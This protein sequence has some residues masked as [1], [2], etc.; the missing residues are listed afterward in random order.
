[1][2]DIMK[3]GALLLT[4]IQEPPAQTFTL[5]R[6]KAVIAISRMVLHMTPS[7]SGAAR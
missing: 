6:N 3:T 2:L 5:H 7:T 1:M 4:E